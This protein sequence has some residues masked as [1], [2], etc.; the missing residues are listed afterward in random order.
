M[1]ARKTSGSVRGRPFAKGDDPRRAIGLG[2]RPPTVKCIADLL[3][4]SGGLDAPADLCAKMRTAFGIPADQPLTVDQAT[5]LRCRIEAL[6]GSHQHLQFWADRTEGRVKDTLAIEGGMA[7][8]VVEEI[9]DA[10]EEHAHQ[11]APIA[12]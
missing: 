7:L 12:S 6:K 4:W 2:G 11:V 9:V 8:A 5:I 3:R 1:E 10:T